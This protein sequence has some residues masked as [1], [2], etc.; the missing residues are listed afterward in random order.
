M[1]KKKILLVGNFD[2]REAI[3]YLAFNSRSFE[4]EHFENENT[5]Y[6]SYLAGLADY[7]KTNGKRFNAVAIFNAP[8]YNQEREIIEK[9]YEGKTILLCN[10]PDDK[11]NPGFIRVQMP[12]LQPEFDEF[13]E[14]EI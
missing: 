12:I 2:D 9:N 10:P 11:L 8:Q 4:F 13:V 14:K 5:L 3:T 6:S 1:E 7:L